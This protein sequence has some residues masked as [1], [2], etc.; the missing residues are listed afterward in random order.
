MCEVWKYVLFFPFDIIVVLVPPAIADEPTDFLVTRQAPAVIAC[1][2]SGVP[3]PS[4]HWT[5]NGVRL[6]PRGTGYRILSSG[7]T[8]SVIPHLSIGL[9]A[10]GWPSLA[11]VAP[12]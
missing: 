12:K 6:L 2:A 5:K 7:E 10:N 9:V 3:S 4:I 8:T 1:T 11:F